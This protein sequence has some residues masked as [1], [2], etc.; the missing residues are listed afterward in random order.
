MIKERLKQY[1]LARGWSQ[2][3]LVAQL[4]GLVT[5][6]SISK[7]ER[8]KSVPSALVLNKIAKAF[9]VKSTKLWADSQIKTHFIAY[10][11]SSGLGKKEQIRVENLVRSAFEERIK[12]QN[13]IYPGQKCECPVLEYSVKT[14]QDVEEVAA[15]IRKKWKLGLD[16]IANL[17]AIL[18]D[19]GIHILE[20]EAMDK[21]DGISAFAK[22]NQ[23][24]VSVALVTRKGLPGERQRL[25]IAHELGHTILRV[26]E[27]LDEEKAAFRFA[28]AFLAPAQLIFR[29]IGEKRSKLR[30]EELQFIKNKLGISIQA[31]I[32]RIFDLEIINESQYKNLF[33]Q[34]NKLGW[35]K[36][37]PGPLP[38]EKPYWLEQTVYRGVAENIISK[39]EG[40][41]FLGKEIE[42]DD[43]TDLMDR[44]KFLMLP[45]EE[46]RRI[47]QEQA[48]S[49]QDYYKN[50]DEW[51]D[52][53]DGED[54]DDQ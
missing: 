53:I 33:I 23:S 40:S 27:A 31:I 39:E 44:K 16:G 30:F 20:I 46:R 7:Y 11:K 9:G 21:F 15:V 6:A 4:G 47:M 24:I 3:E 37:E 14:L 17:T 49:V 13:I 35:R 38:P 12:L 1:R 2:D 19:H 22:E 41:R 29:E 36:E 26:D 8:G 45:M 32:R 48:E 51:R 28:A 5:K 50:S 18:E 54:F 25:N 43:T 42:N 10:R 34:I 52:W